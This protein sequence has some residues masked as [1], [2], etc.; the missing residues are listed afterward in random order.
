MKIIKYA[1]R[2]SLI[3]EACWAISNICI[4]RNI[5][6]YAV[7]EIV[8]CIN[9]LLVDN[10]H[11]GI[12]SDCLYALARISE[13]GADRMAC[14]IKSQVVSKIVVYLTSNLTMY[15]LPALRV[16]KSL[17]EEKSSYIRSLYTNQVIAIL[18]NLLQSDYRGIRKDAARCIT[19]LC[20]SE[21]LEILFS[22]DVFARIIEQINIETENLAKRQF[23]LCLSS[24]ILCCTDAQLIHLINMKI[25]ATLCGVLNSDDKCVL[26]LA[27][28]CLSFILK[29]EKETYVDLDSTIANSIEECGGLE[30]LDCLRDFP[31]I[32]IQ[33][34][35]YEVLS[36]FLEEEGYN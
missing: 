24:A 13:G 6:F 33:S 2:T 17:T 15:V 3:R 8:N 29:F 21:Y 19:K 1:N 9:N 4:Y 5:E 32:R 20:T 35:L 36:A 25:V 16:I 7:E 34:K 14:V 23:V 18:S 27:L 28:D 11:S 26:S 31:N 12:V 10:Q 22:V 30:A